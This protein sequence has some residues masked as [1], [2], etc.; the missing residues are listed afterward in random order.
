MNKF[1]A[2]LL[3]S[4]VLLSAAG[5][6]KKYEEDDATPCK[7]PKGRL[8]GSWLLEQIFV[9]NQELDV[10]AM[11]QEAVDQAAANN[12]EAAAMTGID[13]SQMSYNV[14]FNFKKNGTGN[15]NINIVFGAVK[16]PINMNMTWA[17]DDSKDNITMTVEQPN[18]E[19]IVIGPCKI[20]KLTKKEFWYQT[21]QADTAGTVHN[22]LLKYL[23]Q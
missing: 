5:G 23:K 17:F 11:V 8:V 15:V 9:D 20:L 6:C 22:M 14:T 10:V 18:Q 3:A 4:I 1:T 21:T 13:L 16:Y 12:D 7:T 2:F 19:P